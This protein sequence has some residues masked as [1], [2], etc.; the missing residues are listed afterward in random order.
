MKILRPF[1][2]KNLRRAVLA[3]TITTLSASTYAQLRLP[4]LNLPLPTPALPFG[5]DL[6]RDTGN[7]LGRIG[8]LP[9]LRAL[10]L[11]TVGTLLRRHRHVLAASRR[12]G[13]KSWP[14]RPARPAWPPPP[15]PD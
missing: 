3:L 14:G 7:R 12:C 13:A 2:A 5:G 1:R 10:R 8:D 15:R 6:L 4:T 11:E 9:D